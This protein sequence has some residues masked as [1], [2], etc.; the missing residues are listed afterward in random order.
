MPTALSEK[1]KHSLALIHRGTFSV[2]YGTFYIRREKCESSQTEFP[3]CRVLWIQ[4]GTKKA[5]LIK[6]FCNKI[7]RGQIIKGKHSH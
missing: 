6:K 3:N 5:E 1:K 4:H 2:L 7:T